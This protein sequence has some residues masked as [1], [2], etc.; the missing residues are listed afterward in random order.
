MGLIKTLTGQFA[1]IKVI[2]VGGGGNNAINSMITEDAI[3]GVDF[4]AVNTD[5]QALLNSLASI[6]IQIG[7]KLTKGLGAGG[8]PQMGQKAAE[9]SKERIKEVLQGTDMVF[10]TGG[11]GGGT[12]T[13]AAPIIAQ[14]AKKELGILTIGV[15]TKPFLFE[16]TRRMT[17]AEEGISQLRENVDTLIVIPNQKVMEVVNNKATLLEA[18]KI[19]DSVLSKGTKAIAD[20]ITVPGLI[21]LDFADIKAVMSNAG[22]ALMGT[23]EAEGENRIQKAVEDAVDSPLVEVNIEGAR[24]VL[25]NVT[26]GPDITMAEIEE[27]ARNITERTAP[28]ANIIFGATIDKELKGKV[29]IS[30]IAT[31]FDTSRANL[32]QHI[33]KPQPTLINLPSQPKIQTQENKNTSEESNISDNR[34]KEFLNTKEVPTGIDIIDEYDIPAFLR[35][36]K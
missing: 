31:G 7:E 21:N 30:V 33:K 5:S 29:K 26:G 14:I 10:V 11:M 8:N 23:G 17:N 2:G 34:I 1:K 36:N 15:V 24:G 25:I 12:C 20:L 27:A 22:S 6:K 16:G 3:K 32:Y 35:K 13:G 18:F 28:D 19:A 4:I 9:E